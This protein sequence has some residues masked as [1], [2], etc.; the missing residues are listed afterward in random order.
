MNADEANDV[1][2]LLAW[3]LKPED[4][5]GELGATLI[6]VRLADSAYQILRRGPNGEEVYRLWTEHGI[7][8][9]TRRAKA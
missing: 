7:R 4:A 6:A 8:P 5:L 9:W 2:R 1:S 3:L